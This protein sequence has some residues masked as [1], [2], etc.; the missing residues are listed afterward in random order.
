[1]I[2]FMRKT[3]SATTV[4]KSQNSK[5]STTSRKTSGSV[6]YAE[7]VAGP[8]LKCYKCSVYAKPVP[9]SRPKS[10]NKTSREAHPK[11]H[12]TAVADAPLNSTKK[13]NVPNVPRYKLVCAFSAASRTTSIRKPSSVGTAKTS[14]HNSMPKIRKN[15]NISRISAP[16]AN[17]SL[18][19]TTMRINV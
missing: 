18:I 9:S 4:F 19:H 11:N 13:T 12:P 7:I 17:N 8:A 3:T 10:P 2:T 15:S 14:S 1:M 16:T 5:C 6:E